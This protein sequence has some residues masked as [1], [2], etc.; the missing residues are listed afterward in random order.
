VNVLRFIYEGVVFFLLLIWTAFDV[1]IGLPRRRLQI[2]SILLRYATL[3]ILGIFA[4]KVIYVMA[5]RLS[6]P[7]E[8]EW[9][10]GGV[11]MVAWRFS[12]G[13]PL[14]PPPEQGFVPF[15]YPP[16]YQ[17]I[18][19]LFFK[20]TGPTLTVGRWVSFISTFI[21]A[22]MLFLIVRHWTGRWEGGAFAGLFY[23]ATYKVGGYWFD[24]MRVDS[25][26]WMLCFLVVAL[27]MVSER[28]SPYR[29]LPAAF[30]A[31]AA[32][33]AKQTTSFVIAAIVPCVVFYNW[34]RGRIF[35]FLAPVVL[36]NIIYFFINAGNTW[37]LKHCFLLPSRH[38][39]FWQNLKTMLPNQLL[40]YIY[41]PMGLAGLWFL[42]GSWFP[43]LHRRHLTPLWFL[44]LAASA[45]AAGLS[46]YLKIG[47]YVNNFFPI[48]AALS[49]LCGL[50]ANMLWRITERPIPQL[51]FHIVVLVATILALKPLDFDKKRILPYPTSIERGRELMEKLRSLD[52]DYYIPHHNFYTVM[53]GGE[54]FYNVDAVR[55]M[56]WA[57]FPTP[58]R[59]VDALRRKKFRYII[60]DMD[61][62]Y[63][64]LPEEVRRIIKRNYVF[65]G[66]V[67]RYRHFRELEPVTG[68]PMKPQFLW[69]AK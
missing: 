9:N 33:F 66:P 60:L 29:M 16:L 38:V 59:L 65:V 19:G 7:F 34:R 1:Y 27:V 31:A 20:I 28:T 40:K 4:I 55:D 23:L 51:L 8:L 62:R 48:L 32:F 49:I 25:F 50:S 42:V 11:A 47:G 43:R 17:M 35:L 22:T 57:G 15:L 61:I 68:C 46:G 2:L 14:Y 21:L 67:V 64:W 36:V 24:L 6:Y 5:L 54:P 56:N 44:L 45:T 37:F 18:C 3:V 30:L 63:E 41:I 26:T 52:G 12:K 53:A 10:E 39:V 69:R 13:L 58:R